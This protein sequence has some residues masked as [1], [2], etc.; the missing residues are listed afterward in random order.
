MNIKSTLFTVAVLCGLGFLTAQETSLLLRQPSISPNGNEI[1]FSYQGD[2][3]TVSAN[4]GRAQRLTIHESYETRPVWNAEGNLIAFQG[5]RHGGNDIFVI[6]RNGQNLQRKTYHSASDVNPNWG[7]DGSLWFN[8]RRLWQQTERNPEIFGFLPG[9]ATPQRVMGG[10]G[11]NPTLDP[12]GNYVAFERGW[13]RIVREAYKGSANRDIWVWHKKS[14]TYTQLT[15]FEGQD[16]MPVWG[17]SNRLY[18]LSARNGRYN[19]YYI[20]FNNNKATPDVGEP[21]AV[22]NFTDEG[23]RHF[24]VNNRGD[25]VYTRGDG[26]VYLMKSGGQPR[27]LPIT[28]SSDFRFYPEEK[29]RFTTGVRDF[30]VSPD[31]KNIAFNVRG[32]IFVTRNDKEKSRTVRI[33]DHPYRD[34]ETQWL[35]DSTLLFIS[36][37]GGIEDLYLATSSDPGQSDL[38]LSLKSEVKKITSMDKGVFG[39]VLSPDRKK[40]AMEIGRGQLVVGEIDEKGKISNQKTLLDGWDNPSGLAW[41]PD[42]QWLAYSLSDLDFNSEIYVHKA[43]GKSEPVNVSMHPRNDRNPVWSPD[44]SKLGFVSDRS[45]MNDN[46]WFVWLQ[47]KDFEQTDLTRELQEEKSEDKKKSS[48][49]KKK[50]KD[51]EVKAIQIDL[52]NI[53][54]RLVQVTSQNGNEGSL[55]I[56]PKGEYFYYT[57]NNGGRVTGTGDR[58]LKKIKWDGSDESVVVSKVS[59]F[60]LTWDKDGKN[61][62]H[63][64]RGRLA[65]LDVAKKKSENRPFSAAMTIDRPEERKQILDEAWRA[66]NAGFYDPKFHGQDWKALKDQYSPR[67]LKASTSQDFRDMANEMLGQ[68]N[69]SH[70]GLSGPNPEEVQADRTGYIGVEVVP[71]NGGVE[72][73]RTLKRTPA[74]RKNS[75]LYMGDK[76]EAVNGQ[77]VTAGV[78]F[79]S[80]LDETREDLVYLQVAGKKGKREVVIEPSSSV[81]GAVYEDWVDERR[82]LTDEY[83]NGQ[84]GYIHIQGMNWPSFEVFERELTASAYGK[85][86]LIIDVRNNGG[87]WTTDMVMAILNNRQHS[88]TVPRG[89]TDDL[90]KNHRQFQDNYPFGERLPF[91]HI[92]VPTIAMCNEG[93]YSNAE[94]FSHAYQALG[95]G[96]V[97]GTPTFGAVIS[98]GAQGLIDGSRVRMPFRAW[99]VKK[100]GMNMENNPATPDIIVEEAPDSKEKNSDPQLKRAVDELLRSLD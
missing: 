36:D 48:E 80:L 16:H 57:T 1:A 51:K 37:R 25:I 5:N 98:T 64:S 2:I 100:S 43:D 60:G 11:T 45:D 99:Y 46:V 92:K 49:G 13:C 27:L 22:T 70:M 74:S 29:E 17:D 85:K 59:A 21:Q 47:E 50:S 32:E 69:A 30:A 18:F 3:W 93:S 84:L 90:Q 8:T 72:V 6:D 81:R 34:Q 53:H 42:S 56:G 40:I 95:H 73:T 35:N 58:E 38:Y 55:L 97:V 68:L 96:K 66:L 88:Y 24:H 86:G 77:A 75:M 23:V 41:S 87:G 7:P 4:G 76:I 12:G 28:V 62:Y 82:R 20:A 63:V 65:V 44:G 71:V 15:D 39:Y 94:I 31:E 67:I 9:N 91:P 89:A 10:M 78:N 19:I 54:R 52:D 14:D 79:W 33:T 83:S 61:I 26:G